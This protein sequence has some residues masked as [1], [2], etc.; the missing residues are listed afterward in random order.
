MGNM[1]WSK[2][3]GKVCS[4]SENGGGLVSCPEGG[5]A[6]P[7]RKP[8]GGVLYRDKREDRTNRHRPRRGVSGRYRN[9]G[10]DNTERCY[11]SPLGRHAERSY[12]DRIDRVRRIGNTEPLCCELD[13]RRAEEGFKTRV[14]AY[15]ERSQSRRE[16]PWTRS[17]RT[18]GVSI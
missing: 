12:A 6:D 4:A 10:P 18:A 16:A 8:A 3:R 2:R 11:G 13:R 1:S 17:A 15:I 5:T 14:A 9:I 7:D